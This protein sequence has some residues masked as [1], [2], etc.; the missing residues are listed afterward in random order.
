MT[1]VHFHSNTNRIKW[2]KKIGWLS[3][4]TVKALRVCE[5]VCALVQW[6]LLVSGPIRHWNR[7][8]GWIPSAR[9]R[10]HSHVWTPTWMA[11]TRN[12]KKKH[13]HKS[14]RFSRLCAFS[15]A[16]I[17][18]LL[19]SDSFFFA[20]WVIE[21]CR[22]TQSRGRPTAPLPVDFSSDRNT[23]EAAGAR[24]WSFE[25]ERVSTQLHLR[26]SELFSGSASHRER[27]HGIFAFEA[28]LVC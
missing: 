5:G 28:P 25:P 3:T 6:S 4:A 7:L 18:T 19:F 27:M 12:K 16:P 9:G 20:E 15:F 22:V 1:I 21:C 10:T 24:A 8:A 26:E 2:Q 11:K 13:S 23:I 14:T 17:D